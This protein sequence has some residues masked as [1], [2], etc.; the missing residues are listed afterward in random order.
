MTLSVPDK[1]PSCV[2]AKFIFASDLKNIEVSKVIFEDFLPKALAEGK[3]DAA[4]DP[5][6]VG[7]GLEYIQAGF[8]LQKKGM[9][10][11]KVLVSL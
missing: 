1:L 2:G 8:V 11:K 7:K 9:S 6:V 10:A 3:Y 4:P 5:E